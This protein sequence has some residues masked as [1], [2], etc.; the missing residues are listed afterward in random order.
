MKLDRNVNGDGRGKYGLILNRELEALYSLHGATGDVSKQAAEALATLERLGIIDWAD[1]PETEA[2][3]MR[4]KDVFARPALIG[5]ASAA[6]REGGPGFEEYA[7]DVMTLAQRAG[8]KHPN[9][10]TPD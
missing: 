6:F 3:V 4:L 8:T 9:C 5:Y 7:N 2:F 10:K 1:T